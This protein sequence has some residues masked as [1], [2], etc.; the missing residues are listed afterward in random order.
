MQPDP[1]P[2][3]LIP[4]LERQET[5]LYGEPAVIHPDHYILELLQGA[6][7]L[8]PNATL[9]HNPDN[10]HTINN[11]FLNIAIL[12]PPPMVRQ[13]TITLHQRTP[14]ILPNDHPSAELLQ[15]VLLTLEV[16]SS[17][18]GQNTDNNTPEP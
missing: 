4:P 1:K 15:T 10:Q 8:G 13:D 6:L 7:L 16:D 14:I 12:G 2:D 11:I 9:D 18:T 17:I 3:Y 5:I